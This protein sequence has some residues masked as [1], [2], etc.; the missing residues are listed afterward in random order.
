M[1]NIW[2]DV[3]WR[4]IHQ[5][6][7]HKIVAIRY[8][9]TSKQL[10]GILTTVLTAL[11]QG[12]AV[13]ILGMNCDKLKTLECGDKKERVVL[14]SSGILMPLTKHSCVHL[15]ERSVYLARG[16]ML[17]LCRSRY[18][19]YFFLDSVMSR[20][21]SRGDV[22][23]KSIR[24]NALYTVVACIVGYCQ[25]LVDVDVSIIGDYLEPNARA[26]IQMLCLSE[27]R[28]DHVVGAYGMV[29]PCCDACVRI[30]RCST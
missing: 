21:R 2:L 1:G 9:H 17:G 3:K 20:S 12:K 22:V 30:E 6:H 25:C 24:S 5:C 4:V 28:R 29:V 19:D 11:V 14:V 8:I 15:G 10:A 7:I 23:K 26:S 18:K 16:L 13:P 27:Q